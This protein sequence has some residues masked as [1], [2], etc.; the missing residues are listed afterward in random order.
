MP[1]SGMT[2]DSITRCWLWAD[3][4]PH[5]KNPI[6]SHD[7][8]TVA[9]A[10]TSASDATPSL[11]VRSDTTES[12]SGCTSHSWSDSDTSINAAGSS[13]IS[14]RATSLRKYGLGTN[15]SSCCAMRCAAEQSASSTPDASYDAPSTDTWHLTGS[16]TCSLTS[17]ISIVTCRSVQFRQS[18]PSNTYSTIRSGASKTSWY[19]SRVRYSTRI[20]QPSARSVRSSREPV[21]S[22]SASSACGRGVVT[23]ESANCV[24]ATPDVQNTAPASTTPTT[25]AAAVTSLVD[26]M[27]GF[28]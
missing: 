19:R 6:S 20:G 8:D 21:S 13:M 23:E 26:V 11:P 3:R 18:A 27:R 1:S 15:P 25:T 5:V 17:S 7:C 22:P 12:G 9:R 2:A 4:L 16:S 14:S 10:P 28:T 24:S